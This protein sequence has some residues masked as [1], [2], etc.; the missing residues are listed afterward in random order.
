[1]SGQQ[2]GEVV[3]RRFEIKNKNG[4]H[5]RAATV[6]IETIKKFDAAVRVMKDA[7]EVDGRSIFGLLMLAAVPGSMI[8]VS[9]SGPQAAE[10]LDAIA[11]LIEDR[12]GEEA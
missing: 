1:M 6:L 8:D 7:H 10:A 9:A 12:F 4:L 5:A 3:T 11:A 2:G